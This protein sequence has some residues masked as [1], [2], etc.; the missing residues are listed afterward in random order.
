VAEEFC[1]R[2]NIEVKI[3]PTYS[4][5]DVADIAAAFVKVAEHIEDLET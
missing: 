4:E 5:E 1:D 2:R 3:H